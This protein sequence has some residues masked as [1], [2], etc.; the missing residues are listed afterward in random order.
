LNLSY[1]LRLTAWR[2]ADA[3]RHL[4]ALRTLR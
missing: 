3:W 2:P 1:A 4:G